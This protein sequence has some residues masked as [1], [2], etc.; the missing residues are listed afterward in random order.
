MARRRFSVR[1]IDEILAHWHQTGSIQSTAT[2]LGVHRGT[3]RKYIQLARDR[4]YL[5][6]GPPPAQGWAAFVRETVPQ[7]VGRTNPSEA[8]RRIALFHQAIEEGLTQTN[9][10]TVWQRLRD[11]QGL[12]TSLTSF[13]RYIH[14]HFPQG[15]KGQGITVRREEPA[16][17]SVAEVD[18]G[19]L[20]MWPDPA[21]G[22]LRRLYAFIMVLGHSRHMFVLVTPH[23]D[24]KSW[25]KAHVLAFAFFGGVPARVVLD[26]LKTGVLKADIY[27]PQF[28][29]GYAELAKYYGFLIDPARA[30]KP[31][32]KPQV[33]RMVPYTRASFWKGRSFSIMEEIN[34]SARYWCLET[35]GQRVHGTTGKRPYQEFL[36]VEQQTLVPLPKEP[37]QVSTWTRAKVGRDCHIQVD[38]ALYSVPYR[39]VGKTLEVRLT[40]HLVECFLDEE[41]VKVHLR[42]APRGRSTRLEDYPPEKAQVLKE[43]PQWCRERAKSLGAQVSWVVE[44]LLEQP[45]QYRLRQARGVLRL[46]ERYG[47]DRL[48]AACARAKAF[49]DPSYRTVKGILEKGLE[50]QLAFPPAAPPLGGAFLHGAAALLSPGLVP[51][52][53]HHE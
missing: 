37:F 25:V 20:G 11:E 30:R 51:G 47:P 44:S 21:T 50:R 19:L 4:G 27:D 1:D 46:S 2:S 17:G 32:D 8:M 26:N 35:A 28:N 6:G 40:D 36:A 14:L 24:Q 3:V 33:E 53:D 23:L 13:Y 29:R 34:A 45:T 42:E 31:K 52:E 41:L 22:R 9:T 48:D 49:G 7:L 12:K 16:P 5:P 18:Y 15:P 10:A 43:K 39:Y 38:R